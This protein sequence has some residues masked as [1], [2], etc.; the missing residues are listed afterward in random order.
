MSP[1]SVGPVDRW[2]RPLRAERPT[3]TQLVFE[4]VVFECDPIQEKRGG[5]VSEILWVRSHVERLLQD[6]WN[7]CRVTA[8][9]DGDYQFRRGTAVGWVSILDN[10]DVPLVRVFAFA[11]VSIKPSAA[12]LRE[13]N[14]IQRRTATAAIMWADGRVIVSQTLS[15]IGITQ[16][17]LAQAINAVGGIAFDI[18]LLLAGMFSGETPYPAEAG[19]PEDEDEEAA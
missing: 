9:D 18:G 5:S 13:L 16:A 12:L 3:R 14:D 17:V 10:G 8:D 6:E 4:S 11:A 2:R 1:A 15:P 19:K 7:C